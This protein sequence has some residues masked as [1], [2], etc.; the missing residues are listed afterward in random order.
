MNTFLRAKHWQL[1]IATFGLPLLFQIFLMANIFSQVLNQQNPDPM[2]VFG[3]FK[4]FPLIMVLYIA[5]LFGWQWSV[6]IGLKKFIPAGIEMKTK[7][8]KTFF[9]IPVIYLSLFLIFISCIFTYVSGNNFIVQTLPLAPLFFGV[10]A[11]IIPLHL[12]CMFCLFY[13]IYFIA[14]TLKTI[15]LQ[16]EV[17]FS[18]FMGEF[19]LVWFFPIGVWI[20]QP[21]INKFMSSVES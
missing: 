7:K 1:F 20:L 9:F 17:S 2:A 21:R 14:K 18:D 15:E 8:F 5:A 11:L 6:A 19:F 16:R 3:F 12:F 10:F 13:S 4:F